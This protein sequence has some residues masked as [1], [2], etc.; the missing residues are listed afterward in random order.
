MYLMLRAFNFSCS[1]AK[2]QFPR[3]KPGIISILARGVFS[4]PMQSPLF[5]DPVAHKVT[6]YTTGAVFVK[7]LVTTLFQG[8]ARFQG[9]TRPPEDAKF[10]ELAK[11][12]KQD[13]GLTSAPS[14]QAKENDIRW[15][16]I[17]M[18]DLGNTLIFPDS[19]KREPSFWLDSSL[20]KFV[21]CLL[22]LRAQHSIDPLGTFSP[23]PHRFV[24]QSPPTTSSHWVV[25]GRSMCYRNGHQWNFGGVN[26]FKIHLYYPVLRMR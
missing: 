1:C 16:R 13:Y 17:V 14:S 10:K 25:R 21:F 4:Q 5:V 6:M 24:R 26:F 7:F 22:S 8:G 20:G 18:N 19:Q 9:G 2:V 15:Q 3:Y 23:L 11:G 12:V